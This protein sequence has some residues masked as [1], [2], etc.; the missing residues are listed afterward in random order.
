MA[1]TAIRITNPDG[2]VLRAKFMTVQQPEHHCDVDVYHCN[3]DFSPIGEPSMGVSPMDEVE[4][5]TKLRK[6]ADEKGQFVR[7]ESTNP[8]FNPENQTNLPESDGSV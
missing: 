5:H 6:E 7:E 4:Y 2:T 1:T 8:E 3:E